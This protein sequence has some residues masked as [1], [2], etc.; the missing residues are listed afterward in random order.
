MSDK[1]QAALFNRLSYDLFPLPS[2]GDDLRMV[3]LGQFSQLLG[4]HGIG[5]VIDDDPPL[6]LRESQVDH[7]AQ[8]RRQRRAVCAGFEEPSKWDLDQDPRSGPSAS[9]NS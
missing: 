1:I 6:G 5:L 7:A 4:S 9:P 2:I 8:N 3:M